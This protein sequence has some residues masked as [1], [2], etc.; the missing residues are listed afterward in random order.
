MWRLPWP[1]FVFRVKTKDIYGWF[2]SLVSQGY[3]SFTTAANKECQIKSRVYVQRASGIE[4][5]GLMSFGCNMLGLWID[6]K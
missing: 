6:A 3:K 5:Q 2:S 4:V 1:S